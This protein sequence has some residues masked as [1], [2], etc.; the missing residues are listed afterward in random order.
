M[1]LHKPFNP[2]LFGC[3]KSDRL[4]WPSFDLALLA[5]SVFCAVVDV[6]LRVRH[7][8]K[9]P[10]R[11]AFWSWWGLRDGLSDT[12]ALECML[13]LDYGCS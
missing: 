8:Y 11:A 7:V 6:P 10:L 4:A 1:L 3:T 2:M 5:G 12:R 13:S 9:F